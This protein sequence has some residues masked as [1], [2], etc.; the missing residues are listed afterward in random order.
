MAL[1]FL[2]F[3]TILLAVTPCGAANAG[4]LSD[5]SSELTQLV[6]AAAPSVVEINVER[7]SCAYSFMEAGHDHITVR[8]RSR[9]HWQNL[10]QAHL[11][12]KPLSKRG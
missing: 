2:A 1:R 12:K 8:K 10:V 6:Q 3:L 4:A 7:A 5:L 11:C 9:G